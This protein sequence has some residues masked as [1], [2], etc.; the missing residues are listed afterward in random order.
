V[1]DPEDDELSR[2]AAEKAAAAARIA[3]QATWVDLQIVQAMRRG[4]FENLSGAGK[5]IEDLGET[6]DPDWWVK[7]MVERERIAVLPASIALR[8]EDAELD[9]A[10]DEYTV[11]SEVREHVEDFNERVIQA[12]YALPQG[13]P[14]ITMPRDVDATVTAWRERYAAFRAVPRIEP[15]ARPPKRHWWNRRS[16]R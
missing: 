14:L 11:E 6:H 8:K 4:E 5:P 15:A 7:R 9:D 2:R 1:S 16:G 13:P 3:Q 10:L 12:R